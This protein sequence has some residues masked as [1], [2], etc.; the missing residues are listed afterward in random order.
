MALIIAVLFAGEEQ[1][2]RP[3]SYNAI[4]K[5]IKHA[6]F[7]SHQELMKQLDAWKDM[8]S[9]RQKKHSKQIRVSTCPC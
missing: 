5:P 1:M 8:W 2:Q 6:E 9:G 3:K 7:I 4:K